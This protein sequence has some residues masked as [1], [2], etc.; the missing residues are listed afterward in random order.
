MSAGSPIITGY[1]DDN[2]NIHSVQIQPETLSLT[3]NSVANAAPTTAIDPTRVSARVSGGRHSLGLNARI[4]RFRFSTAT[5]PAGYNANTPLTLPVLTQT[6]FAAYG[7]GTTGT[8][9]LNGTDFDVEFVG[10]TPETL[11]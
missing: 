1:E 8:Y 2:G 4:V 10:K 9:T 3:L 11:R 7:R 6:A 5:V